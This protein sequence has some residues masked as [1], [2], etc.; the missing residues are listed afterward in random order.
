[1][2]KKKEQYNLSNLH[3]KYL[4]FC[5]TNFEPSFWSSALCPDS[6]QA[7]LCCVKCEL[8]TNGPRT[9]HLQIFVLFAHPKTSSIACIDPANKTL[10]NLDS[11]ELLGRQKTR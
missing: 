3:L 7:A 5:T 1:V 10:R 4:L 9:A 8:E 2:Q 11:R 6:G